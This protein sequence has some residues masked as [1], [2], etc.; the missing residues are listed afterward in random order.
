[1]Q[2]LKYELYKIFKQ[3]SIYIFFFSVF[4]ILI[5]SVSYFTN[6]QDSSLY[7]EFEGTLTEL[8]VEKASNS[9][10]NLEIKNNK[11][12]KGNQE[13]SQL[14]LAKAGLYSEIEWI[15]QTDKRIQQRIEK[16]ENESNYNTALEKSMLSKIDLSYFA[17][18]RGPI[19]AIG[20]INTLSI[21]II[22]ALLLIGLSPIYTQ[23]KTS[24]VENYI[25]SSKKGRKDI[26]W[27]KIFASI[28]Y[29][30]AIVIAM[31]LG[32]LLISL[33]SFGTGGWKT[34]IQDVFEFNRSPYS[35][36]LLQFHLVQILFN[37]IA[38][39]SFALF[40][41][42]ISAISKNA[43][44]ALIISASVFVLPLM[45]VE[46]LTLS[47]WME[48]TLRFT[49]IYIMKGQHFFDQFRTINFFGNAILYAYFAIFIMCLI[50]FLAGLATFKVVKRKQ[51]SV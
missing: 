41:L 1:M 51:I 3:K 27:A 44:H 18:N 34:P 38:A 11:K 8:K 32:N 23:E 24:G 20:F 15:I 47:T 33:S 35:F 17:F 36:T 30:I 14:D 29:A 7:K 46:M 19:E 6:E 48:E 45:V 5:Y 22:G 40:I 25:L 28:I 16:L 37:L 12:E 21:I 43:F 50:T 2:L 26:I 49:F 9:A 31:E 4:V 10:K 39:I 42:F 13:Y